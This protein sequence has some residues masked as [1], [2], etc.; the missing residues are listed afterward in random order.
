MAVD[1]FEK[2]SEGGRIVEHAETGGVGGA[3]VELNA[4][5]QGSSPAVASG[6]FV[7]G[8]AGDAEEQ[9]ENGLLSKVGFDDVDTEAGEAEGVDEGLLSGPAE[10][11]GS[12]VSGSGV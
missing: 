8:E 11:S 1:A 5:G 6:K 3:D 9:G 12:G 10:E 2:L 7:D 4:L